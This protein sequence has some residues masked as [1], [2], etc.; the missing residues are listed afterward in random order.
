MIGLGSM[1]QSRNLKSTHLSNFTQ[2]GANMTNIITIESIA[3]KQA[4]IAKLDEVIVMAVEL[5]DLIDSNT[6]L[7]EQAFPEQMA[8]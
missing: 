3:K 4:L 7:M 5:N 6:K 8:A 1:K 2:L